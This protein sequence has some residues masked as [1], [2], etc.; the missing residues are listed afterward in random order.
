MGYC[1]ETCHRSRPPDR[2]T[3]RMV[4][5]DQT[6]EGYLLELN[7]VRVHTLIYNDLDR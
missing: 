6:A 7:K 5:N 1:G 4:R 2:N 3:I